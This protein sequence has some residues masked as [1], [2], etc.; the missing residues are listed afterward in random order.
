VKEKDDDLRWYGNGGIKIGLRCDREDHLRRIYVR[1]RNLG[2]T[3]FI[4]LI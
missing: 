2:I 3:P 4:I 1:I